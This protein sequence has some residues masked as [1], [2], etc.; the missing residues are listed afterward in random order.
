MNKKMLDCVDY[1]I[2]VSSVRYDVMN[3]AVIDGEKVCL[4]VFY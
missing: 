1:G 2:C 3:C 4:C